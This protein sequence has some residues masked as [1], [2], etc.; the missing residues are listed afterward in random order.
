[1]EGKMEQEPKPRDDDQWIE[2]DRGDADDTDATPATEESEGMSTVLSADT[3]DGV[4]HN[5]D[6]E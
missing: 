1:M 6:D 2:Q 5:A 3:F 4:Q